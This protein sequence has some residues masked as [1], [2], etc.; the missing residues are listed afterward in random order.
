MSVFS[1]CSIFQLEITHWLHYTSVQNRTS[2]RRG[3][4]W[5]SRFLVTIFQSHVF[6]VRRVQYFCFQCTCDVQ[7]MIT[8]FICTYQRDQWYT[9]WV[10]WK[11]PR[12]HARTRAI[13]FQCLF[14]EET[15]GK[16]TFRF[17]RVFSRRRFSHE[18]NAKNEAQSFYEFAVIVEWRPSIEQ[19]AFLRPSL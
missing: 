3:I 8:I 2:G 16:S 14:R 19:D 13:G 6:I 17:L 7:V 11:L 5:I 10:E 18:E 12:A 1:V 15:K 9:S 4:L